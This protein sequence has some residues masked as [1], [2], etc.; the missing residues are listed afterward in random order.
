M[1]QPES[2]DTQ[3]GEAQPFHAEEVGLARAALAAD[4]VYIELAELFGTLADT[5]RVKIMHALLAAELCTHDLAMVI[6]AAESGVSQHLRIL[7]ALRLVKSRRAGKFVYYSLEDE[8]IALLVRVGQTHLGHSSEEAMREEM[9]T[10][11]ARGST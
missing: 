8:H 7:R 5:T 2:G 10:A 6:G 1:E 9:L 3:S 11:A 4:Q